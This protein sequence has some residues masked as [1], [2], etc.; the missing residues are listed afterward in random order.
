MFRLSS[1][2]FTNP[3]TPTNEKDER[4]KGKKKEEKKLKVVRTVPRK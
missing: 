3:K 2:T 4:S 1:S